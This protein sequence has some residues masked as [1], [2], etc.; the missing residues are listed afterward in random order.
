MWRN[1]TR[2]NTSD[3]YY[4]MP[5]IGKKVSARLGELVVAIF[6]ICHEFDSLRNTK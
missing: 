6:L 3:M 2:K 1:N 4:I 5:G